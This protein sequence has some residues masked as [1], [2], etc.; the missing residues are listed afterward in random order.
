MSQFYSPLRYPGGKSRIF[1]FVS[2]V[3]LENNLIGINY[4]EP[5]AGGSG[6]AL[7]LLI[8]EYVGNIY[9]NDLDRSI[10][11]FWK[12]IL[13][14]PTEFCDWIE[15]VKVNIENWQ[16]FKQ[17]QENLENYDEF[18]LAKSTFFL[19]RTNVSGV[20]KGGIIG[21]LDQKGMYKIDAR[22]NKKSLIKRIE[23]ISE[24]GNRINVSRKDGINFI[25]KMDRMESDVFV[26]LDPPYYE[27]AS[28]LYMNYYSKKDHKKLSKYVQQMQKRWL[29]SYDNHD[30]ILN[31][32]DKNEKLTY[33]LSHSTSNR[34]GDEVL[35]FSDRLKFKN[36]LSELKSPLLL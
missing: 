13:E 6:L 15:G 26:Y 32:Y 29:V 30:F 27:K 18:E 11:S 24:F 14:R 21:G 35:V 9:I 16:H 36:S 1:K 19:N 22:F 7:K 5:Y 33:K 23:K 31:L 3:L 28:D 12:S 25:K 8:S 2:N 17:I 34:I 20:I 10:Y 4:A